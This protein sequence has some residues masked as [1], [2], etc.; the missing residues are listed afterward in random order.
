MSLFT[1]G[2][3]LLQGGHL[4]AEDIDLLSKNGVA[5]VVNAT[6]N[7]HEPSWLGRPGAP[8]WTRFPVSSMYPSMRRKPARAV[9]RWLSLFR[10]VDPWLASGKT[11]LVHCR[12]GAHRAGTVTT[13]MLM[14]LRQTDLA[15]AE[16]EAS[17]MMWV[18]RRVM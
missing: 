9:E 13:A 6:H 2:A 14:A 17:S 8:A 1:N 4:V 7:L 5:A 11:V 15:T 3:R 16:R 12:A 18:C 10:W